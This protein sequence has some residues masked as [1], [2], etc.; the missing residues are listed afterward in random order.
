[1]KMTEDLQLL[2]DEVGLIAQTGGQFLREARATF[3]S[4][5]IETKHT[6]DY[7]SYVDRESEQRLVAQLG[8][9]L[10]E[11]GFITEEGTVSNSSETSLKWVI[12]P[13]DGTTNFLRDNP[14]YCISIALVDESEILLGVVYEVCRDELYTAYRDGDACLNGLPIHVSDVSCLDDAYA[15]L[16]LP[17]NVR[18]YKATGQSLYQSLYGYTACL[19]MPGSAAAALCYIAAGRFDIW[20]EAFIGRWDYMAGAL[21]VRRAGGMVTDFL[22]CSDVSNTHHIAATNGR[23]HNHLLT[24]LGKSLPEGVSPVSSGQ[25]P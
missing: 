10:P 7:V 14:P 21:I 3:D 20:F 17:Y 9:L 15:I 11:A 5:K 25:Q 2:T 23:L 12:D 22:G 1:M 6:H 19:R 8:A 16:E 18:E 24:M 4:R 13:L